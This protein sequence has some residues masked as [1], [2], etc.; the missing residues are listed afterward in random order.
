MAPSPLTPGFESLT[1]NHFLSRDLITLLGEIEMY[2]LAF[3]IGAP[4]AADLESA[5]VH[6]RYRLL[7]CTDQSEEHGSVIQEAVRF[8]A[9]L[10]IVTL[11]RKP[12]IRG[13]DYTVMLSTLKSHLLGFKAT[14][15]ETTSFFLWLLFIGGIV[16]GSSCRAWFTAKLVDVLGQAGIGTWKATKPLLLKFWWVESIHEG[17]CRQLW[18]EVNMMGTNIHEN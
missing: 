8:G 5:A 14:C 4:W 3:K 9:I 16:P 17:P 18:E 7:C 6:I 12:S 15:D 1:Q 2:N 11:I 10:Y 13:I